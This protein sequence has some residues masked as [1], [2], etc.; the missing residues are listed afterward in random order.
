MKRVTTSLIMASAFLVSSAASAFTTYNCGAGHAEWSSNS[1]TIYAYTGSFPSG[2]PERSALNTAMARLNENSSNF[3][4]NLV[5]SS[6]VPSLGNGRSE[7]WMANI[8]P[9]GVASSWWNGACNFTETDIRLDTSVNWTTSTSKS[10]MSRY[11]GSGRP[12]QTTMLHELGHGLGLGHE[13]DEYNIMGQDYTHVYTNGNSAN[14]YF[15]EDAN[16]GANFLYGSDGRQDL[17]VVHWKRTGANNGYSQHGRTKLYDV[18]TGNEL[19]YSTVDDERVYNVNRGQQ[20]SVELTFEN[21]GTAYQSEDVGYYVSTNNYISTWDRLL[22]TY[23]MGQSQANVYTTRRT[24]TIPSDLDCSTNYWLGAVIDKNGSL[25]EWSESN[26]ATYIPI[27]TNW[28][29]SCFVFTPI[30]T[31]PLVIQ[32]L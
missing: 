20:V 22:A 2:S 25:N 19:S 23:T 9:P 21:N 14:A 7:I 5:Y 28:N 13:A 10:T 15:G 32:P 31:E 1:K 3:S 4:F 6:T 17:G 8:S 26:N 29:F 24:V 11:G 18:S 27:R 12:F 16:D 30:L